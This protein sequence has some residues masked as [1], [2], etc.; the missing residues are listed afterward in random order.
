[1]N[2]F[3]EISVDRCK[4][5]RAGAMEQLEQIPFSSVFSDHMLVAR[6]RHGRW[7]EARICEYG[8]LPLPPN[9][10]ALQYGL[11]VFEGLKVHRTPA[12]KPALFRPG[13]N[14]QRLNRSARRLAMPPVPEELFL[15]GLRKLVSLDQRWIPAHGK[16]A[17][18]VRPCLFSVD[19][20]LRVKPPEECLFVTFTFPY[21]SYF[22]APVELLVSERY[23][24]AFP[25]GTGDIKP[26]GNYAATVLAEQE[27][28]DAG[29][30]AVL[31]LDAVHRS[32]VE[33]CGVMNVFF[34]LE[35]TV[36]TPS[37]EG[38]IL[39]GV[40]RDCALTLLRDMGW[41]VAERPVSIEEVMQ[42]LRTGRLTECFGTATAANVSS[43]GRIRYRDVDLR[44]PPIPESGIA[45]ALRDRLNGIASGRLPDVHGWL[46]VLT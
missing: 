8:S 45:C 40:T 2:A 15:S 10:S 16:G 6:W 12:G 46:E 26:A 36:V 29:F 1:V 4:S 7:E 33:E 23:V 20:S 38:T 42:A 3:P 17:L 24:R 32:F 27:A 18:Y 13:I 43:V 14:A 28:R 30:H 37:L 11:S 9:I 34:V 44:L 19:R 5:T 39:P 35:D 22:T 21:T 25:G 31:W 41:R